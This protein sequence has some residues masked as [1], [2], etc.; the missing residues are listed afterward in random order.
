MAAV[1]DVAGPKAKGKL[2]D[3]L[4]YSGT[5]AD[6]IE[7]INTTVG[8]HFK[9]CICFSILEDPVMLP[10]NHPLCRGCATQCLRQNQRCPQCLA[11]IPNLRMLQGRNTW[12][13]EMVCSLT[14]CLNEVGVS[15][16]QHA[17][18]PPKYRDKPPPKAGAAG[19]AERQR[20][21]ARAR[22][23]SGD[24]NRSQLSAVTCGGGGGGG[25]SSGGGGRSRGRGRRKA[26]GRSRNV[27]SSRTASA[28]S[29]AE[30]AWPDPSDNEG[31]PVAP[32]PP[33][34]PS[35]SP[36]AA[37]PAPMPP[38]RRFVIGDLV[39]VEHRTWPGMNKHGGVALVTAV[40]DP[41]GSRYD[42]KY[43]VSRKHDRGVEARYVNDFAFP[44]ETVGSRSR[45]GGGGARGAGRHPGVG[46]GGGRV[47]LPPR[48]RSRASPASTPAS[49][50]A[51]SAANS[52]A[53]TATGSPAAAA[54]ASLVSIPP[55]PQPRHE[56]DFS[57]DNSSGEA[58][59][60]AEGEESPA[61]ERTA[62]AATAATAVASPA[63]AAATDAITAALSPSAAAASAAAASDVAEKVEGCGGETKVVGR[64][65]DDGDGEE[66]RRDDAT[67]GSH[68]SDAAP[69]IRKE[70]AERDHADTDADVDG[71]GYSSDDGGGMEYIEGSFDV[72]HDG[73]DNVRDGGNDSQTAGP[74]ETEGN[75]DGDGEAAAPVPGEAE[76]LSSAGVS[77]KETPEGMRE[78]DD[79]EAARVEKIEDLT[80]DRRRSLT[81]SEA[82]SGI[83]GGAVGGPAA[84]L[85][86][87]SRS[88]LP[89]R[90]SQSEGIG[91]ERRRRRRHDHGPSSSF[92]A[93]DTRDAVLA[94]AAE[95]LMALAAN[96]R[97]APAAAAGF[98]D[99]EEDS[100][101]GDVQSASDKDRAETPISPPQ[102][103]GDRPALDDGSS[104]LRG[105][106]AAPPAGAELPP[107]SPSS[108]LSQSGNRSCMGQRR[109]DTPVASAAAAGE[110]AAVAAV[111]A[112][113]NRQDDSR[114]DQNGTPWTFSMEAVERVGGDALVDTPANSAPS[115][116]PSP[117]IASPP[118]RT[119]TRPA[120]SGRTSPTLQQT[121]RQA[122]PPPPPLF[123]SPIL[124]RP[125]ILSPPPPPKTP[126]FKVGDLVS[127]PSR[128]SP[129]VNKEGGVAK[130]TLARPDGTFDVKYIVRQGREK[131]VAAAILS[132]YKVD[133]DD[134]DGGGGRGERDSGDGGA[135][136]GGSSRG[137]SPTF[138][139]P[140]MEGAARGG[141]S[142]GGGG[143]RTAAVR[144][145][146]RSNKGWCSPDIAAGQANAACLNY[147]LGDTQHPELDLDPD[148][149]ELL[150]PDEGT[151]TS[152]GSSSS[153]GVESVT[154][155]PRGKARKPRGASSS[156]AVAAA[157]KS[158]AKTEKQDGGDSDD[159]NG[160][161][162]WQIREKEDSTGGGRRK[163]RGSG[164]KRKRA[165][166]GSGGEGD[167]VAGKG[168]KE[169]T[170]GGSQGGSSQGQ[171]RHRRRRSST[172]EGSN[173]ASG[174]NQDVFDITTLSADSDIEDKA[175]ARL[176][177]AAVEYDGSKGSGGHE[178]F[179]ITALSPGSDVAGGGDPTTKKRS[180]P[181]GGGKETSRGA[182]AAAAAS[183]AE[184]IDHKRSS[185]TG[186]KSKVFGGK[187]GGSRN[188]RGD[189]GATSGGDEKVRRGQAAEA[190]KAVVLTLSG[191]TA[192]M[193]TVANALVK[194]LG[195]KV[196]PKYTE[197]VT[198]VVCRTVQKNTNT[199][200]KVRSAKFLRAVASGKWVVTEAWLQECKRRGGRVKEEA[201]EVS[202]DR[203]SVVPSAPTR[204]RLAHADPDR[205]G[206]FQGISFHFR[207]EF[208]T[209]GSPPLAELQ[210]M[211]LDNGGRVVSTIASLFTSPSGGGGG[212]GS[213]GGDDGSGRRSGG[214]GSS[215]GSGGWR[216]QRVVIF[217]PSS[218]SP[219]ED[220]QALEEDMASVTGAERAR[221][222]LAA[223]A[224]ECARARGGGGAGG[225][226]GP[227]SAA[228]EVVRPIWLVDSVGCFRV[229]RPSVHHRLPDLGAVG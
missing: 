24:A 170:S 35:P 88:N 152:S 131:G 125:S 159:A 66:S 7:L 128:T 15:L 191:S 67:M 146:P 228:I 208:G 145:T 96:P 151:N 42:V 213:G 167:E 51:A 110:A 81:S 219:E 164:S 195:W 63:S 220:A 137:P 229:L 123:P 22:A 175:A 57:V 108:L 193:Q 12:I 27:G 17:P 59:A 144:R 18:V 156:A 76:V 120:P 132:P 147:M 71:A 154:A 61:R 116:R 143:R 209:T 45:R 54:A 122:M 183:A 201:F 214:G 217:Q 158:A 163:N 90:P 16:T 20:A 6:F 103:A 135:G 225:M 104:S 174:S 226:V 1:D 68:H 179:D 86:P 78:K 202:G 52:S 32:V 200:A 100:R 196:E 91:N 180:R 192:E 102:S 69:P 141:G 153:G 107:G 113:N 89:W 64:G 80:D 227:D 111:A 157:A 34:S 10:C 165:A 150:D 43:M 105:E 184:V 118:S 38:P 114:E 55:R 166:R 75:T 98:D 117:S 70:D 14:G 97:T 215:S 136:G 85:S 112:G 149:G 176:V 79:E 3:E 199:K 46:S 53:V 188:G 13:A 93:S 162:G 9:C 216:P 127:V 134:D 181:A 72:G 11:A 62:S 33:S 48:R 121:P 95:G 126:S 197:S 171:G 28:S 5:V 187:V 19:A 138:P 109:D 189:G 82:G 223:A 168:T 94:G 203:K 140:L 77:V 185:G 74:A 173:T 37:S 50:A 44:D 204:S 4:K 87:S 84:P 177:A 39:F 36:S 210:A 115:P 190:E 178:V 205:P 92:P 224:A 130:V 41:P 73:N 211:L 148:L 186:K 198:H 21:R 155:A 47:S 65:D 142:G 172:G 58:M 29:R 25:S 56:H 169:R 222:S 218:E 207:G 83:A 101:T 119:S 26:G 182:T 49:G 60:A 8:K 212:G 106:P 160:V 133:D 129:G 2:E 99:G 23:S 221:R 206:L 139:P 161:S 31:V 194:S 40:L 124:T 30:S